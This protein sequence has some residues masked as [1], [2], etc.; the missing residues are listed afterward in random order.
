[1]GNYIRRWTYVHSL[2]AIAFAIALRFIVVPDLISL[3]NFLVAVILL[4]GAAWVAW[5]T[6]GN[7]QSSTSIGHVLHD[8]EHGA[9]SERVDVARP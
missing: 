7:G 4:I 8:T 9:A 5:T 6:Y 1:M 2:V 3:P